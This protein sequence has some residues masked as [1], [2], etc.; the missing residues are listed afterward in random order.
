MTSYQ[1]LDF[2][3]DDDDDEKKIWE[4]LNEGDSIDRNISSI[5]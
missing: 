2:N 5:F 3:D 4:D 1:S